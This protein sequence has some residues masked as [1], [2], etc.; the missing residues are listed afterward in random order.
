M[1]LG[2]QWKSQVAA[3]RTTADHLLSVLVDEL[4]AQD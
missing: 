4:A 1:T 2:D 3:T